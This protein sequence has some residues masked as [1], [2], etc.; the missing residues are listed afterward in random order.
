MPVSGESKDIMEIPEGVTVTVEGMKVTV[1]GP[2]GT[3]TRE[4]PV[5]RINIK[6]DGKTVVLICSLPKRKEYAL[7]GTIRAHINNMF[8]GVT[9]GFEYRMKIVYSHFPVK[10]NVKGNE[11]VIENF[12]GEKFPR[13]ASVLGDTKITVS[14]D[15]VTLVG[16]DKETVGQTAANIE[17][18]TRIKNYDPRKFQDGIYIIQKGGKS[19]A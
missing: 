12:L 3:L 5:T 1:K 8:T 18:V 14:G 11:F 15:I 4:F 17:Q 7:Q 9:K 13:R 2:K 19:N 16:I 6:L 10:A